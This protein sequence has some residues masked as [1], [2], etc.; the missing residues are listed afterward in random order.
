MMYLGNHL[1]G[2]DTNP[3]SRKILFT[4]GN[5]IYLR[6]GLSGVD[7][8]SVLSIHLHDLAAMPDTRTL[9]IRMCSLLVECVFSCSY[10][11]RTHG[12]Y[13]NVFSLYRMFLSL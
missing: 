3:M 10:A 11:T 12:L 6:N 7:P 2:V 13:Q 1:S 4:Y 9:C 8:N 5:I